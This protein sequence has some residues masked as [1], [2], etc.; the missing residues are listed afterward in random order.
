MSEQ[1][2]ATPGVFGDNDNFLLEREL[3]SGG[4]GGVYMGRDK[5]LDRPVAVKV[6]LKELGA[7]AEFV[8]KFK[9][10]AQ[11]AARLV[12]PNIVQVYSY[13]ICDGMPYI[14]MELAAGGSLYSLM[15]VAPGKTDIQRVLKICQQTAQALQC[16]TD[17]GVIH[18]DV[19]PEN[20]L[21]DANGNAKLVDFGLAAMQ[22]DTEEIWGTPY[23]IAPEK[24]KK[25]AVDFRADMYSL[26]ATLYHALTGVAPFEG[27]DSIAVVKKRF[28]DAPR[29]PSEIR[30]EIS[31]AVDNLVM[32]MIELEKENRF[33]SFEALLQAFTNVLASGLTQKNERPEGIARPASAAGGPAKRTTTVRGRRV[34]I[35]RPTSAATSDEEDDPKASKKSPKSD[36][37]DEEEESGSL[38]AKVVL[39]IVGGILAIGAVVGGLFWFIAANASAREAEKHAQIVAG[40]T[41][42]RE[43]I[44]GV[45]EHTVKYDEEFLVD[46]NKYSKQCDDFTKSLKDL[47]PEFADQLKPEL[48]PELRKAIALT[49]TVAAVPATP[50]STAATATTAAPDT[51]APAA[52]VEAPAA[53]QKKMTL[54][55]EAR[56]YGLEPPPGDFD[57]ADPDVQ[58]FMEKLKEARAKAAAEA[59]APKAPETPAVSA[60][61]SAAPA[62]ADEPPQAVTA[63]KDMWERVYRFNA[64]QIHVHV[65][66]QMILA[67]CDKADLLTAETK[68]NMETLGSISLTVKDLYDQMT[69][70]PLVTEARK[71][72]TT[73]KSKG[74]KM[75]TQLNNDLLRKKREEERKRIKEEEERKERERLAQLEAARK[76]L[77][78]KETAEISAKF[79][80]IAAQ[81]CFRQLDW[82]SA[83][84]QLNNASELFKTAEGKLATDLQ[85]KKVDDMKKVQDI[86]IAKLKGHVFKGKLKGFAVLSVDEKELTLSKGQ[87][88]VKIAWQKFYKEFPGNFN[89]ILNHYIVNG[90]KNSGLNLRDW[91]DA[92]TGAALTMRLVCSD[93]DGATTKAEMLA[94]EVVKQFSD[95]EKT[96]KL[97]FPDMEF[98]ASSDDE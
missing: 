4:M 77:I 67:E 66:A 17:Q 23:Y 22:K 46:L 49:N 65:K 3:G 48:I 6:M 68:E 83:L 45:R 93:V 94:K 27:D 26:G 13:G 95:Y 72:I 12:H 14:A 84:R 2:I 97:I 89:E 70:G 61:V 51:S 69:S 96:M 21:L 37:G 8:E 79:D 34:M 87:K 63:I 15:N 91:A 11:A 81:G 32:T 90:R 30:P 16:A 60:D 80:A 38:G 29:K 59:T 40:I 78:E 55:E 54:Q 24:V 36:V 82:K 25:T 62:K 9:K 71:G 76:A 75:L 33:P 56:K 74:T 58:A 88:P 47:I 44:Q 86:F 10:E 53:P 57:P 73:I 41:K 39:F 35:K 1:L 7:D 18:G 20:I 85:I 50:S 19:K 31:P 52:A 98:E 42:A 28:E 64:A 5:M 92:M 43:A